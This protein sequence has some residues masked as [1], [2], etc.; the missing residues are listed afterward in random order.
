MMPR[1][2]PITFDKIDVAVT[3]NTAAVP[4]PSFAHR[5]FTRGFQ[6]TYGNL[7]LRLH[8]IMKLNGFVNNNRSWRTTPLMSIICIECYYG[9]AVMRF[10][11]STLCT[12]G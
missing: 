6:V 12:L 2:R 3:V 8:Y 5:H 11:Y 9:T 1:R 10:L 4:T 7:S